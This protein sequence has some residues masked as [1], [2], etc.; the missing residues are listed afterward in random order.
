MTMLFIL[1][2][3]L[4]DKLIFFPYIA[5]ENIK[6]ITNV[7]SATRLPSFKLLSNKHPTDS[8]IKNL[9]FFP[10]KISMQV[11]ISIALYTGRITHV[12]SGP[13]LLLST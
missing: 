12:Y 1:F 8:A 5:R 6:Y 13:I 4:A 3:A 11:K 7:N 10:A 9:S 2:F